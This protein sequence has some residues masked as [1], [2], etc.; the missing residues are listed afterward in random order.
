MSIKKVIIDKGLIKIDPEEVLSLLGAKESGPDSHTIG[1]T[2]ELIEKCSEIMT[3]QGG[4]LSMPATPAD[5]KD[6]IATESSCF[7]AGQTIAK[8]LRGSES[9][10]FFVATAGYG[11]EELS[12]KLIT[13]GNYL[14]G[15]I[16]DLVGSAIAETVAI[17]I[18]DHIKR[19]AE[20]KGLKVTN[21]Y[22]PGYCGWEVVE[23]QK[24]FSLFPEGW[25]GISLSAS[26]LM[27]PIKSVSGIVGTGPSVSFRDYTC[28]ICSM[29][30]CIFR[31]TRSSHPHHSPE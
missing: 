13:D 31:R 29:K 1:L 8:M 25:C 27:S 26:S 18:H 24:L 12:R 16:A 11:P 10:A 3:P 23:Q 7:L 14:E 15:Y 22:S 17:I 5:A 2:E 6:E 30:A 21:R 28:E 20:K 4:Y 9:Y 19:E